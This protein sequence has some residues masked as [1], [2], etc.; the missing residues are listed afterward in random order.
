VAKIVPHITIGLNAG[1]E[2]GEIEAIKFLSKFE[3]KE[4]SSIVFLIL[5]PTKNTYFEHIPPPSFDYVEKIFAEI[6]KYFE[7]REINI[8][9]GCMRPKG[10]Y[11]KKIDLLALQYGFNGIVNPSFKYEN[12]ESI[13]IKYNLTDKFNKFL[14]IEECCA[15]I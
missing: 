4:I 11:R 10:K 3:D 12:L 2:S 14:Y 6:K 1:K 7:N 8:F 15:L 13:K 5:I 9:L